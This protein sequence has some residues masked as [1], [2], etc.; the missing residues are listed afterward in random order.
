MKEIKGN[1]WEYQEQG[2][3]IV[4][5]TNGQVN[6][7]GKCIMG[8]GLAK[9]AAEKFPGLPL[10]IGMHIKKFGNRGTFFD[11]F[12]IFTFPTKHHWNLEAD[13]DLIHTSCKNIKMFVAF[14]DF[15][16][17]YMPRVGCG[18][19]KLLWEDVRPILEKELDDRFIIVDNH[20]GNSII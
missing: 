10:K 13:I 5:P 9:E 17:I 16:Q 1:I 7:Q 2:F 20:V 19:G 12:G 3:P 6:S 4:V 14:C 15:K 11:E 18:N 8:E